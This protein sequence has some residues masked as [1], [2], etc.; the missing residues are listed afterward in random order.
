MRRKMKGFGLVLV[1]VLALGAM[2][3]Q[4]AAGHEFK[5]DV[6]NTVITGHNEPGS[7]FT[8]T[9]NTGAATECKKASFVGTV[10]GS[11]SVDTVTLVPKLQECTFAGNAATVTYEDCAIVLESDTVGS[12][13]DVDIECAVGGQI[14]TVTS[15]CTLDTRAQTAI[16]SGVHYYNETA[17]E[18]VTGSATLSNIKVAQK[19]G[20]PILCAFAGT[21]GTLTGNLTMEGYEFI[22]N[23][24]TT[25]TP[26]Y[27]AGK[28][29]GIEVSGADSKQ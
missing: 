6:A 27:T 15:A 1:A 20:S 24:G 26:S 19:T 16:E 7:I 2:G 21:T 22:S 25:T 17:N 18:A 29:V 3:A 12:H 14:T 5:S 4:G 13:A 8:F 28:Q 9:T 11:T 23:S 10:L